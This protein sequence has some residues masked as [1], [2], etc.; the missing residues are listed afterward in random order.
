MNPILR[1]AVPALFSLNCLAAGI[2]ASLDRTQ[3]SEGESVELTLQSQGAMLQSTPDLSPLQKDFEILG[4]RQVSSLSTGAGGTQ[5]STRWL[6]SLLPRRTGQL[7]IPA[8]QIGDSHSPALQLQVDTSN[9][10]GSTSVAPVFIDASLSQEEV[11]VQAQT[12][13]TL[14]IYHSV[15]L[16]DDSSLTPLQMSDARVEP[17]GEPKTFEQVINGVRHGVIELRY[18]IYPQKSGDLLIPAQLFSATMVDTRQNQDFMPFGSR[19]GKAARVKSPEIPL[20]VKPRPAE[21]PADAPWLPAAAV[22]LSEAWSPE[23]QKAME[24][25]SLT[26][27]VLLKAD[28]LSGSQLPPLEQAEVSGLRR[29]PEQPQTRNQA[30]ERGLLGSREESV[31]LVPTRS[32]EIVLPA[33]EVPWWNTRTDSLE[34]A[35]LPERRLQVAINPQLQAEAMPG[36]AVAEGTQ[37]SQRLWPWQLSTGLFALTTALGFGLWWRARKQPAVA[38]T[39][40]TGPSPRTLLDDLKRACLANDSQAT[41]QALDAWARQQPETLADMAARFAPLSEALDGLNGAL[42]SESGQ[43]WQGEALWKAVKGLPALSAETVTPENS[44]PP[45]YPR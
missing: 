41:R 28:G 7:E 36:G 23:P 15:S 10:T 45:L 20:R 3:V 8:L 11:Y 22:S 38:A 12:I 18:A 34:Y 14:R 26:R 30:D 35:R 17:L 13:L 33:I 32:G 40:S 42:Y 43:N 24:G 29:Y 19:P 21:F 44:L 6:I 39:A 37:G 1:A 4:S 31:A 16:Y 2:S 27:N 25:I 9:A 5:Q